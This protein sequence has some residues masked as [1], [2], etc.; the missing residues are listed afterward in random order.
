MT[1]DKKDLPRVQD[2]VDTN[3]A[4]PMMRCPCGGQYRVYM[5]P[6]PAVT[7]SL[8]PCNDYID[9]EIVDFLEWARLHGAVA[10]N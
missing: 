5:K 10:V 3:S 6:V 9:K 1:D 4:S 8:P 7:H 2:V